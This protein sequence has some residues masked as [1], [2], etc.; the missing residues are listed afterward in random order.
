MLATDAMAAEL[1][2]SSDE[3]LIGLRESGWRPELGDE[4]AKRFNVGANARHPDRTVMSRY[5]PTH[6]VA[7]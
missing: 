5:L 3:S 6:G 4:D 1:S 7:P 2:T